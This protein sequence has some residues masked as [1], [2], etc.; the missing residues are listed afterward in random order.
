MTFPPAPQ[1]PDGAYRTVFG[2][3]VAHNGVTYCKCNACESLAL[4]RLTAVRV[5]YG[6]EYYLQWQ[7][8]VFHEDPRVQELFQ[9]IATSYT[10]YFNDYSTLIEEA[11]L[12]HADPHPKK[13]LRMHAWKELV[14]NSVAGRLWLRSVK[15]KLKRIEIAKPGK[16]GR[17]IGDLGVAASLQGFML[18]HALKTAQDSETFHFDGGYAKFIKSPDMA[19]LTAAFNDLISPPGNFVFIFFSDDACYS[20]RD[21]TGRVHMFNLDI[22]SCD[23]SHG[24]AIF[25]RLEQLV[26]DGTPRADMRV[27]IDQCR[28]PIKITD[29]ADRRRYVTL[30]PRSPRLY[31]GSTITTAI[32]NVANLSIIMAIRLNP[33][34]TPVQAAAKA[35][36]IITVDECTIPEDLQFLKHSPVLRADATGYA[37]LLNLGVILRLSG[38]CKGDLPGRGDLEARAA[39]FQGALIHGVSTHARYQFID[40]MR[41]Q[42]PAPTASTPLATAVSNNLSDSYIETNNTE[43]V[44]FDNASLFE[45]YRLTV[46]DIEEILG[47]SNGRIGY[48]YGGSALSKVLTKDYGLTA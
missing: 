13:V 2:P 27:L 14:Q 12:H 35:G 1:P 39:A 31:S 30:K 21:A 36:Y 32:N 42:Y 33:G 10:P 40:N 37:P 8:Q 17:M 4:R 25:N 46:T 24:P 26:P 20:Y 6:T 18:T 47:F 38:T 44:A 41:R 28:L 3:A 48:T 22:S 19:A 34:L 45:R 11:R 43:V 23:A 7:Q 29:V 16:Y 5:D 9:R 15:Y